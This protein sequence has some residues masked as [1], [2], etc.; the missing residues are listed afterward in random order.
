MPTV[1]HKSRVKRAMG[2][3]FSLVDVILSQHMPFSQPQYVHHCL[4]FALLCASVLF[5]DD[6]RC[7]FSIAWNG[8]PL[9]LSCIFSEET[10]IH[11]REVSYTFVHFLML[12]NDWSVAINEVQWP[13]HFSMCN[14]IWY[15]FSLLFVWFMERNFL[16]VCSEWSLTTNEE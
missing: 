16:H 2:F 9:A 13:P 11:C 5:A 15:S 6:E 14:W 8:F 1:K 7:R 12:C 3:I 10:W 4:T